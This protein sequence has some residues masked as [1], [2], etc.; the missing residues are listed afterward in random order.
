MR[1]LQAFSASLSPYAKGLVAGAALT[2]ALGLAYA[3]GSSQSG[4]ARAD[5]AAVEDAIARGQCR[6]EVG[7]GQMSVGESCRFDTVMVGARSGYL[8]CADIEVTCD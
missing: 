2:A 4:V 6:V 7:Y 1:R 3:L 5:E 8:L